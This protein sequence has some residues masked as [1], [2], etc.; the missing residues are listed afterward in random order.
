MER[1]SFLTTA[2][3]DFSRYKY[4]YRQVVLKVVK[5]MITL[6]GIS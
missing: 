6:D 2:T 5:L 3:L 1:R 4:F